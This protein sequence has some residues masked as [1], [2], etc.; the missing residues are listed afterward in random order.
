M[1]PVRI[2]DLNVDVFEQQVRDSGGGAG[3]SPGDD[4]RGT[5]GHE[6]VVTLVRAKGA[7]DLAKKSGVS[8]KVSTGLH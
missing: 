3:S 6:W 5:W 8:S 1:E 4:S 2:L 7:A